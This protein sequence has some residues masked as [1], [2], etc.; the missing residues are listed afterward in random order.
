MVSLE[1]V[2]PGC[3][4]RVNHCIVREHNEHGLVEACEPIVNCGIEV[5]WLFIVEE[6]Q[7]H[8]VIEV[9]LQVSGVTEVSSGS[10]VVLDY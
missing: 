2:E 1:L 10:N 7:E 9:V 3:F 6:G 5:V 4:F 8:R